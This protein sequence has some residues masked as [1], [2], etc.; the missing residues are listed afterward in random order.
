MVPVFAIE[1]MVNKDSYFEL[2]HN[3]TLRILFLIFFGLIIG[4]LFFV[5][6]YFFWPFLYSVIIYMAMRPVY[7][8]IVRY[9]KHRGTSAGLM[10]FILIVLILVPLFFLTMAIVDQ[11]Y[12]LY[13]IVQN[14]IKGGIIEQVYRSYYVQKLT[15]YLNINSSEMARRVTDIV[16][17]LSGKVLSSSRAV[18]EYPFRFIINFFFLLLMIFFLFKDGDRLESVF[19]KTLPFPVDLEKSVVNRLKEVIKVL[20]T[21]NLVIMLIQGF[22]VGIGF[23]IAGIPAAV[24]GGSIAAIMSLIP[25]IG[26]S[27]VWVPAVLYLIFEESYF[28]ALFLGIWCLGFYLLLENIVKPKIFGKRLNFHPMIF[29][30]LII[31]SL[32]AFNLHGVFIGPLLLTLFYSFW[33]IYKILGEYDAHRRVAKNAADEPEE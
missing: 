29:F 21:G 15:V 24:V 31:G 5:F 27:L 6:R 12:Q 20:L 9:V 23:Y 14:E 18:I 2:Q 22:M 13:K 7:D 10:I 11:V 26:T 32:Q 19:Y 3:R 33:E 30:F 28:L 16:Q 8:F 1:I 25:I 4:T 17:N